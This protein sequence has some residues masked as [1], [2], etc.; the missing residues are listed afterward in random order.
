MSIFLEANMDN[1]KVLVYAKS[2]KFL[3]VYQKS[4]KDGFRWL[5][6]E[7]MNFWIKISSKSIFVKTDMDRP[8]III[9]FIKSCF[10][11]IA[12]E[13][14]VYRKLLNVILLVY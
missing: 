12:W 2:L 7:R 8:Q 1:P 13:V 3:N 5:R 10:T 6:T 4:S 11:V 9:F 14:N